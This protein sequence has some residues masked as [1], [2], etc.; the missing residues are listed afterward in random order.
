MKCVYHS[1]KEA[2][3][4]CSSCGQPVCRECVTVVGGKNI[5]KACGYKNSQY[6]M[7]YNQMPYRKGDGISGLLFFIYLLVPGLRHMYLGLMKRGLE[8][9]VAFFGSIGVVMLLGNVGEILIPAVF[10]IWFYSA[11][12]SYQC[13]KIM[14]RGEKIEDRP[15][16]QGYSLE[17]V[18]DYIGQRRSLVGI[19]VIILGV[20]MLLKQL[21]WFMGNYVDSRV[22]RVMYDVINLGF[23][24]IIPIL[25][26]V[27]G[28]Y[29]LNRGRRV[30]HTEPTEGT[31]G[32]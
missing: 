15:I 28:V 18:K 6:N 11:F 14:V 12:D 27:G 5:C 24:S 16:F 9:L 8:F 26:I 1:D 7:P 30:E 19:G 17:Q 31:E 21:R 32:E 13:R 22:V 20:F 2:E 3:F 23:D 25:F 10:I 4:L 29:L